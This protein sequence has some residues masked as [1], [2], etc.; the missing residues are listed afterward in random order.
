MRPSNPLFTTRPAM[1]RDID[2]LCDFADDFLIK[3]QAKA[4]GSEARKVFEH[5]IANP[6]SGLIVVAEH[7]DGICAYAYAS[8]QWRSEFGGQTMHCLELFVEQAW[9]N[10]GVAAS[11]MSSL[12]DNAKGRSIRHVSAEVH[13]GNSTIERILETSGFDPEHRTLWGLDLN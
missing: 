7:Q 5:V 13:P 1:S 11:L 6:D 9:R 10:R 4:T 8:Y 3:M 12:I 2:R